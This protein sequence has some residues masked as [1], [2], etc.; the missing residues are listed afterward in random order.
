LEQGT[1]AGERPRTAPERNC[2]KREVG[3]EVT[4]DLRGD[5]GVPI[6]VLVLPILPDM[7]ENWRR[8]AQDLL[9]DH[10]GEYEALGR[11]LGVRRVRVYLVR[12]PRWDVILAHVEA[13]D[14]AEAFRRLMA[15]EDAFAGWLKEKLAELNGFDTGRLRTGSS[16]ELIF[17]HQ[18]DSGGS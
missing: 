4:M 13:R 8:F 10:L 6:A 14:P 11:H 5:A 1:G 16:S 12:M 15:S 17:E 18:G 9:E 2:N 3:D 7:E